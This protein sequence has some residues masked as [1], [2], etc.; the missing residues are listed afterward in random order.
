MSGLAQLLLGGSLCS[1]GELDTKEKTSLA[2]EED[3]AEDDPFFDE[4]IPKPEQTYGWKNDS[5]KEGNIASL[6][7]TP[8]IN[9]GFNSLIGAS[10]LKEPDSVNSIL[11]DVKMV[12]SKLG[13]LELGD[14]EEYADDFN[15][16]SQRSE[17]SEASIGEEI[18]DISVEL[19]EFNTSDKLEDLTQDFTIS[20][21]SGVADY[22]EDVA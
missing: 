10:P 17:K 2:E 21:L 7:D 20:Q 4:P 5:S 18:E 3:D 16:A 13:S 8:P 11:K 19:D 1:M 6:S 9:S 14:E 12:N 15:S 22:L